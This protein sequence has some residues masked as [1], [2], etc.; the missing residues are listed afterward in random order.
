MSLEMESPAEQKIGRVG[1]RKA[2][3]GLVKLGIMTKRRFF[4]DVNTIQNN[5]SRLYLSNLDLHRT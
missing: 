3:T 2:M 1:F 4:H 5:L